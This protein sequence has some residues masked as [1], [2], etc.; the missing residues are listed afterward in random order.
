VVTAGAHDAISAKLVEVTGFDAVWVSSFGLSA[1]QKSMP[2]ANVLTMTESLEAAKN[3]NAAV[4]IPVI[5]DCDNGYGNALNVMRTAQE[6]AAAGIAGI[7]IE[8]A[9]FPKRCSLY[10]GKHDLVS[11]EEMA[12]RLR[13]AKEATREHP[14]F[15]LIARTEALIA[16]LGLEEALHRA[17]AYAAA[18]ADALLIHSKSKSAEEVL[19]FT[20]RWKGGKPLVVVPTM[21]PNASVEQLHAAGF[22]III[23]ANQA[24]R[25]AVTAMRNQLSKLR[26]E[27]RAEVINGSIAPLPEIYDL[28]GVPEMQRREESFLPPEKTPTTSAVILAAGFEPE[29]LPLTEKAPKTMLEIKGK[30]ILDRQL[31]LLRSVQVPDIAVVRGYQSGAVNPPSVT[32]FENKNYESTGIAASLLASE[33]HWKERTL[34]LYGDILF[35][36]AILERLLTAPEAD[37]LL[38]MDRSWGDR[39]AETPVPPGTE[40]VL[41]E[42]GAEKGVRFLSSEKP[43]KIRQIG[44]KIPAAQASGEFIGLARFSHQGLQWLKSAAAAAGPKAD[45][46][47]LLTG[48]IQAGHPVHALEIYKGWLEVDTVEDYRKAWAKL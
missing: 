47:D 7:S 45:L 20:R 39:P 33:P 9:T 25:A 48:V 36:R 29:L 16:G 24:L 15:L 26:Q 31:H 5:A 46:A 18:G 14:D 4:T 10:G 32:F 12:G 19:A 13:A 1:A 2:D 37:L 42:E 3:I 30:T 22:S 8:D 11:T 44:Q 17:D 27:G 38:V 40:L 23:F 21:F 41:T 43:L 6:F 28:V 34:V 35:D